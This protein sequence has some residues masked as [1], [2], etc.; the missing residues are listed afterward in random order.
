MS[1]VPERGDIVWL[2]F[3]PRIGHE[4]SGRR[5]ALVVSSKAYNHKIGL[6][7]FC[8]I[9]SQIKEY[10]FEVQLPSEIKVQGV[11]SI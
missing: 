3:D 2:N 8:P 10:P 1:Y 11:Y 5:P 9:T 6:T 7:L 4:Q